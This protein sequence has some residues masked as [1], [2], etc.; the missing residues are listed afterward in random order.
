MGL[1]NRVKILV[2]GGNGMLAQDLIPVLKE[3]HDVIPLAKEDLDITSRDSVYTVL[4]NSTPDLVVNCAAYT[5]VDKAEEEREQAFLVNG[6]GVQN[7]AIACADAK[8]PL[9]HIS[10]DYVFDGENDNP[11]TPFDNTNP[12]NVYGKSK[13]AG[14]KYIQWILD[15]FYIIRTSWLY[16]IRGNNFVL[17]IL[18]LS[19]ERPVIRIVNDQIGAPTSTMQLSEGIRKLIESGAYGIYHLT[20]ETDGGISW[21]DF[22]KEIVRVSGLK[23][24]VIPVTTDEFPRP[25]KRPKYSV[26]DMEI[27]RLT[28]G[29]KPVHWKVALGS[30]LYHL[31]KNRDRNCHCE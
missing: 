10:T 14:E 7:L 11:Y 4:K 28:L 6:I 18:R 17:T 19:K 21:F 31:P 2:T 9:C 24:E 25:A 15:K 12:I 23:T 30:S 26:L 5:R 1:S 3:R 8:I 20:D 13:L 22:A 29:F 27:T 16:S